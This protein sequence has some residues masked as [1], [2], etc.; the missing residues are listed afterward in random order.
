MNSMLTSIEADGTEGM[1]DEMRRRLAVDD[2]A[3]REVA[4]K[5]KEESSRDADPRENIEAFLSTFRGTHADLEAQ[6][7]QLPGSAEKQAS[8]QAQDDIA[9]LLTGLEQR[10]AEASYFLPAYDIRQASSAVSDLKAKL[11][12]A[13]APAVQTKRF[14]FSRK[15]NTVKATRIPTSVAAPDAGPSTS[16]SGPTD[17]LSAASSSGRGC[18]SAAHRTIVL[19]HR[20][21]EARDEVIEDLSDC[22]IFLLGTVPALQLRRLRNCQ[23]YTGAVTGATFIADVQGCVVMLASFQVRI[24]TSSSTDFYLLTRSKPVI[25]HSS[26]LRFAP[27]TTDHACASHAGIQQH[28]SAA[29]NLWSEVEDFNWIKNTPSPNWAVLP[30]QDRVAPLPTPV[31]DGS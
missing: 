11:D 6:I 20:E 1:R 31:G 12:A 22:A 15:K 13:R 7:G 17:A 18:C 10:L 21:G 16:S 3:R 23:V 9:A 14:A 26:G 5:N 28:F 8:S 4:R 24:H 2:A 19:T 30:E 27:Y 29:G 25:E